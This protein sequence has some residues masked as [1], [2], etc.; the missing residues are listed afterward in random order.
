[1]K[2]WKSRNGRWHVDWIDGRGYSATT[3]GGVGF[4]SKKEAQTWYDALP[5]HEKTEDG[6]EGPRNLRNAFKL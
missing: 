6:E 3:G 5:A 4:A 1:M 2:L